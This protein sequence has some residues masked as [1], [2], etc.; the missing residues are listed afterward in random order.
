ML[1]LAGE[2]PLGSSNVCPQGLLQGL[3]LPERMQEAESSSVRPQSNEAPA[4]GKRLRGHRRMRRRLHCLA[5]SWDGRSD[6]PHEDALQRPS[7]K[8]KNPAA[9]GRCSLVGHSRLVPSRTKRTCARPAVQTSR[10]RMYISQASSS[11]CKEWVLEIRSGR[12]GRCAPL[13]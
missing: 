10:G 1:R 7:H 6:S 9:R 8:G 4:L 2:A 3:L 11:L 13:P 12:K 5:E